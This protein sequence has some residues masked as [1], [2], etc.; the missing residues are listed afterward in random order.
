MLPRF[1]GYR[2]GKS[3]SFDHRGRQPHLPSASSARL[4]VQ[5]VDELNLHSVSARYQREL[6]GSGMDDDA[7]GSHDPRHDPFVGICGLGD[8]ATGDGESH[9]EKPRVALSDR[10]PALVRF[11]RCKSGID[12]R[13]ILRARIG[14]SRGARDRDR[15]AE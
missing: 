1:L 9:F 5:S 15:Q 7:P 10:D 6:V 4:D 14:S 13:E 11:D 12:D 8:S 2:I 3:G